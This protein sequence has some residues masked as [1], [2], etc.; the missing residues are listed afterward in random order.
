MVEAVI[1]IGCRD[2]PTWLSIIEL[3][4]HSRVSDRLCT[5]GNAYISVISVLP[6]GLVQLGVDVLVVTSLLRQ[7]RPFVTFIAMFALGFMHHIN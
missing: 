5:V 7:G 6:M 3:I 2:I 1:A 4:F